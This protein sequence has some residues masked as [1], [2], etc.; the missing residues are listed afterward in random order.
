MFD[1]NSSEIGT[2]STDRDLKLVGCSED[3]AQILQVT[4][5]V[6]PLPDSSSSE[7]EVTNYANEASGSIPQAQNSCEYADIA[8]NQEIKTQE[9]PSDAPAGSKILPENG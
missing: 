1:E 3:S 2:R 9:K 4:D 7:N 8:M 6:A 5:E